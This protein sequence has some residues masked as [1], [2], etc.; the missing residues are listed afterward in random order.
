MYY[1]SYYNFSSS[2]RTS[3]NIFNSEGLLQQFYSEFIAA[4]KKKSF[5]WI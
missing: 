4:Y 1:T 3:I 2:I 5:P